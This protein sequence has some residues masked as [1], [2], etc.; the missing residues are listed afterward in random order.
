MLIRQVAKENGYPE[1][2][3]PA[4]NMGLRMGEVTGALAALP[5]VR[6][7]CSVVE[8]ATLGEVLELDMSKSVRGP[9]PP[10]LVPRCPTR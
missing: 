1:P 6:T 2:C 8:M 3:E 4:L 10:M 7:A 5:L 9:S